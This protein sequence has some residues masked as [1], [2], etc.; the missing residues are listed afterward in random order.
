MINI[1]YTTRYTKFHVNAIFDEKDKK[2]IVNY[3]LDGHHDEG[4]SKI[5]ESPSLDSVAYFANQYSEHFGVPI[6]FDD[7]MGMTPEKLDPLL[8]EIRAALVTGGGTEYKPII[9]DTLAYPDTLR[10]LYDEKMQHDALVVTGRSPTIPNLRGC[11]PSVVMYDDFS[12][13]SDKG[14]YYERRTPQDASQNITLTA[15]ATPLV[16]ASS[17]YKGS[18]RHPTT[19]MFLDI[20][21]ESGVMSL[22]NHRVYNSPPEKKKS[23]WENKWE[24]RE[25]QKQI[26]T[27]R[28]RKA[29]K[30][31]RKNRSKTR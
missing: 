11:M 20:E 24:S 16:T 29:N 6:T 14:T 9:I 8:E 5:L 27:E 10:M 19:P 2:K 3:I 21:C 26:Q 31:A 17:K 4:I 23:A 1:D 30:A 28:R 13:G 22:G 18:F 12:F 25:K 7:S 15:G